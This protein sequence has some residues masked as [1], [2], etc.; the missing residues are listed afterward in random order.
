M[1]VRR[2]TSWFRNYGHLGSFPRRRVF[3]HLIG[4]LA[5]ALLVFASKSTDASL[6]NKR[7]V[8]NS[9]EL[10]VSGGVSPSLLPRVKPVPVTVKVGFT[11]EGGESPEL[12]SITLEI[13]RTVTF[14]KSGLPSCQLAKLYSTSPSAG[15]ICAG[16]VVGHGRIVSQVT[17]PGREPTMVNGSFTAFY[18]AAEGRPGILAL[19]KS[20][21]ALPLNYVIPFR[22]GKGKGNFG[23]SLYASKSRMRH[24]LGVCVPQSACFGSTYGFEGIYGHISKFE[25]SLHRLFV[26]H[27]RRESFVNAD[28][29]AR[30]RQLSAVF[31]GA[32]VL[33]TGSSYIGGG[34]AALL[35]S[36]SVSG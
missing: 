3:L 15:Q 35:G 36:C 12:D 23:T 19:V 24:I 30:G 20:R 29:P 28:C 7:I 32:S 26:N 33:Y 25:L 11:I 31:V 21:G 27:G 13:S 14:Q 34:S 18:T 8:E 6:A 2:K 5:L 9:P 22:F 16:S 17:L 10:S 1:P 4:A